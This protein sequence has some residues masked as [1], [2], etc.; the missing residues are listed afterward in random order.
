MS[1]ISYTIAQWLLFFFFYCFFGWC[2]ESAYVSGKQGRFVNRGFMNGPLLP[3][4]GSG[5]VMM[6][7]VSSPF[8]DNLVATYFAGVAGATVLE[9]VTG[10]VMEALFHVRYW[11]YSNQRFQY[12]GHI[13]LSSSIA[14]G[15]LTLLLTQV[16]HKPVEQFICGFS[17]RTA[18]IAASVIG[19]LALID[20]VLSFR[21]AFELRALL[22]KL[23]RA[24]QEVEKA[25]EELARWQRRMDMEHALRA[26]ESEHKKE[27]R[28]EQLE[29]WLSERS[30]QAAAIADSARR[31]LGNRRIV[32]GNPG[33]VSRRFKGSMEELK[34]LVLRLEN[35]KAD[36]SGRTTGSE[37]IEN[38]QGE[39]S[40]KAGDGPDGIQR[41]E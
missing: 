6:L 11:D 39:Y 17:E 9:F 24:R 19:T 5:A 15:F 2:F 35:S 4:Y 14:W 20:F 21:A 34:R 8:R 31:K 18:V 33:M 13:C 26:Q 22:S 10:T 32:R 7:V 36:G 30:R 37:I 40:G 38:C 3:I 28:K 1:M 29:Q 23:E 25:K 41:N 16:L 27:Q 12:K